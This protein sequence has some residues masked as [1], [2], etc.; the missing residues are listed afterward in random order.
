M[1]AFVRVL[2]GRAK[3]EMQEHSISNPLMD[4]HTLTTETSSQDGD[5]S[6]EQ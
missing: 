5:T 1:L 3:L 4:T 6:E 2:N